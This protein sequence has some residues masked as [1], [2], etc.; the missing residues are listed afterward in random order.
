MRIMGI[1]F[2]TQSHLLI[3]KIH[4]GKKR[5][6]KVDMHKTVKQGTLRFVM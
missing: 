2:L 5:T 1:Y 6:A 3:Y 4:V